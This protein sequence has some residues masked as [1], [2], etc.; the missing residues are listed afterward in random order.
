METNHK[1]KCVI[2]QTATLTEETSFCDGWIGLL[3]NELEFDW[4]GDFEDFPQ[5]YS[6]FSLIMEILE[7]TVDNNYYYFELSLEPTSGYFDEFK[8]EKNNKYYE[9]LKWFKTQELKEK[10]ITLPENS[11]TSIKIKV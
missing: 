2:K 9:C 10:L 6:S 4:Q 5:S 7:G 3:D 1:I 11:K 8:M